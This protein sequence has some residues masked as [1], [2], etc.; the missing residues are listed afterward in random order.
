MRD[1]G[2]GS[3]IVT[4]DVEV[5]SGSVRGSRRWGHIIIGIE[6]RIVG[7]LVVGVDVVRDRLFLSS[8]ERE[9]G[10]RPNAMSVAGTW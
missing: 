7:L 4:C 6:V 10:P 2:S 5:R 1:V 9:S 8:T 3:R